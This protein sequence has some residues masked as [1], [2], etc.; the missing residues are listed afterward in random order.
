MA[1]KVPV[2]TGFTI[3]NGVGMGQSG[4][5][6]DVWVEYR[7]G[8]RDTVGN[9]TPITAYFYAALGSGQK[10]GILG[11][12]G[13]NAGFSVDGMAAEA[14]TDGAYD[15]TAIGKWNLLGSFDGTI[16]H[17]KDGTKAVAFVGSFTLPEDRITG[18]SIHQ[19]VTLPRILCASAVSAQPVMLDGYSNIRWQPTSSKYSFELRLSMG[20]WTLESGRLYP[21]TG[22]QVTYTD[23]FLPLELARYFFGKTGTVAVTLT[24]YNENH[25]IGTD[26][27]QFAVTVP[28]NEKT[29]PT[30]TVR[31]YP[32]C[33]AFAGVYVQHLGKVRAEVTATDPLDGQVPK[34]TMTVGS[35]TVEGLVSERLA[36]SGAVPVV[37][38]AETARGFR[39]TWQEEIQV[40]PYEPPKLTAGE[41]ARC[42]ADGTPDPGGTH[43]WLGAAQSCSAVD[44]SNTA[45]VYWRLKSENGVY[46][47]WEPLTA[48]GVASGVTLEKEV[49]YTVQLQIRDRAGSTGQVTLPIPTEQVYMHRT[50]NALGLGGYAEGNR[51]L[52]VHWD[53]RARR[54][55][56]GAYIRTVC[57][58]SGFL[59][60]F[61]DPDRPRQSALLL[62]GSIQGMV[63]LTGDT[64]TWQGTD[65]VELTAAQG[66][67]TVTL[68][69]QDPGQMLILS[70]D[71]IAI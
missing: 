53:L 25:V 35:V 43:L 14:V 49:A 62:G 24:T 5:S 1:R 59:L 20:D 27:A 16:P 58:G 57:P 13:L 4:D 38:T 63:L 11:T 66:A 40:L 8:P 52:D 65:G 34:V 21:N 39:T 32:E 23:A 50:P 37:V 55:V 10:T 6:L 22:L 61:T 69:Q 3:V 41:A 68:P 60:R 70:P 18:G 64:V 71:P 36:I 47:E 7:L 9:C 30:V 45:S 12:A 51:V 67:V 33:E 46:G 42:L 48:N 15:F 29:R 44:G 56:S 31:L 19:T 2:H 28:E 54:S 26:T 17:E